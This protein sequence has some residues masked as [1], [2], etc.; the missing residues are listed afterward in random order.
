MEKLRNDDSSRYEERLANNQS[1]REVIQE[2]NPKYF[3]QPKIAIDSKDYNA[4]NDVL[5]KGALLM[6]SALVLHGGFGDKELRTMVK[7]IT[8]E[9]DIRQ[10]K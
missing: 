8:T 3:D 2:L 7:E 9:I 1:I 6:H 4:I 5:S 10:L